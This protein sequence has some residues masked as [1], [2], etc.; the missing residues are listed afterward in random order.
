[1]NTKLVIE[2]PITLVGK[3]IKPTM[4]IWVARHQIG[5]VSL[6]KERPTIFNDGLVWWEGKEFDGLGDILDFI[7]KIQPGQ[8]KRIQISFEELENENN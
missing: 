4:E 1:M 2:E 8:C 5:A 7:P 6:Y 3:G